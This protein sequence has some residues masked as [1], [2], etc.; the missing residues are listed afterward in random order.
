MT[1]VQKLLVATIGLLCIGIVISTFLQQWYAEK[2]GAL[3]SKKTPVALRELRFSNNRSMLVEVMDTPEKITQGLSGRAT[4]APA[5]GMLFLLPA[6]QQPSFWMKDMKFGLDLIWIDNGRIVEVTR[7]VP[8]PTPGIPD[9]LLPTYQP[10]RP[11][12]GVLEV[13]SGTADRFGLIPPVTLDLV[14]P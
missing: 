7:G 2:L 14:E 12:T 11:V 13:V 5:D 4:L 6:R 9:A 10:S 3:Q 8:P 1:S